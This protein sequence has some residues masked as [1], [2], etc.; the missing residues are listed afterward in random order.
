MATSS[1]KG[2]TFSKIRRPTTVDLVAEAL[3]N[4]I[5]DGSLQP[6][7][8]L[9][10]ERELADRFGV[11]RGTVREAIR[12]LDTLGLLRVRHGGATVVAD[13]LYT[14][15]LQLLPFLLQPGGRVDMRVVRDLLELRVMLLEWTARKACVRASREDLERLEAVLEDM[16]DALDEPTRLKELD[17]RF[18]EE[19]VRA[20][21]NRVLRL[22][23]NVVRRVYLDG[24]PLFDA[25]YEPGRFQIRY[26]ER[27]LEAFREGDPA[28]AGQAMAGYGVLAIE[29][30]RL[31]AEEGAFA[32]G[33]NGEQASMPGAGLGDVRPPESSIIG[34]PESDSEPRR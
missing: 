25:L 31:M 12:R 6:G 33:D 17:F 10:G 7:D 23:V 34:G 15:G 20:T 27:L 8:R 1:R 5:L 32:V 13:F 28:V 16:R 18:F 21:G 2:P 3:R 4:A 14:A 19:L 26:H 24:P 22:V 11:N 29:R 30:F 9:P